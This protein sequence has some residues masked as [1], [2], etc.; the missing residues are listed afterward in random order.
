MISHDPF[1]INTPCCSHVSRQSVDLYSVAI[2]IAID[3]DFCLALVCT[4]LILII[5]V[6]LKLPF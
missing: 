2:A 4:L 3:Y 6:D 5:V 1:C